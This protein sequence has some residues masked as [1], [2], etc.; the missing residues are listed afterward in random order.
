MPRIFPQLLTLDLG[1]GVFPFDRG[2]DVNHHL[3][4]TATPVSG[5]FAE[6]PGHYRGSARAAYILLTPAHPVRSSGP[7]STTRRFIAASAAVCPAHP[8]GDWSRKPTTKV[9]EL[10]QVVTKPGHALFRHLRWANAM[11]T[12]QSI[13]E[14]ETEFIPKLTGLRR[15][16]TIRESTSTA[17]DADLRQNA[18]EDY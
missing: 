11:V 12:M 10:S 13:S 7:L 17:E 16:M 6:L 8:V 3:H 18:S 2:G 4:T 15:S 5:A 1:H 9:P 14:I